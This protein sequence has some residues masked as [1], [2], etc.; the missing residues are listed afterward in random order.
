[1]VQAA[2]NPYL[3]QAVA[4]AEGRITLTS[5]VAPSAAA[6]LGSDSTH[7]AIVVAVEAGDGVAAEAAMRHHFTQRSDHLIY[8][9][10]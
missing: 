3:E 7:A 9:L 1:M 6:R 8:Q 4:S 10:M 5:R 2:D